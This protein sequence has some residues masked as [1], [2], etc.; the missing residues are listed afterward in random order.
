[1][2]A[3]VLADN[4]WVGGTLLTKG[5]RREALDP[6]VVAVVGS[7]LWVDEAERAN[8]DEMTGEALTGLKDG[9]WIDG[10]FYAKGTVPPNEVI[11]KVGAHMWAQG[12]P[13]IAEPAPLTLGP[14]AVDVSPAPEPEVIEV[15]VDFPPVGVI[16]QG[17]PE[18]LS[19]TDLD[20]APS[21]GGEQVEADAPKPPSQRGPGSSEAAWRAYAK[22]VGVHVDDAETRADVIATVEAAGKPV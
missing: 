14:V 3:Q 18:S 17:G 13:P 10:A 1:M 21:G 11:G 19:P 8:I 7:H 22:E 12:F 15:D 4:T 20:A 16:D 5:T 9:V 6:D 2:A